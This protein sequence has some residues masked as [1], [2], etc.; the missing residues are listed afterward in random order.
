MFS[1]KA[2]GTVALEQEGAVLAAC[3]GPYRTWLCCLS[4]PGKGVMAAGV[5]PGTP[6]PKTDPEG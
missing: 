4:N 3:Q 6:E 5:T 1:F 2:E